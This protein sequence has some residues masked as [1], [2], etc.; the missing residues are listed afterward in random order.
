MGPKPFR[1]IAKIGRVELLTPDPEGSLRFFV[2]V[3][4]MNVVAQS[5]QSPF[6]R[7]HQ[8]YQRYSIKLTEAGR[9]GLGHMGLRTCDEEALERRVAA[10]QETGLGRD[11]IDFGHGR[12][13]QFTDADGH[14]MELYHGAERFAGPDES[15][16][17][18]KNSPALCSARRGHPPLR[19]RQHA[20]Q[21]CGTPPLEGQ[22]A[23]THAPAAG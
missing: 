9:P 12:A 17:A 23:P 3:A 13:Y 19:P 22:V 7:G 10:V 5:G 15:K 4:G 21:G 11:W 20:P 16:A 18:P 6:L 2:D 14:R 8:D 1:D